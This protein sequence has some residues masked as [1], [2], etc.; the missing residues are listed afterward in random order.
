MCGV[1]ECGACCR[2]RWNRH[3]CEEASPHQ[4]SRPI[5]AWFSALTCC[6][7]LK[8]R[9]MLLAVLCDASCSDRASRSRAL[10]SALP[11]S[12]TVWISCSK[13]SRNSERCE[14]ACTCAGSVDCSD[15]AWRTGQQEAE[16]VSSQP[17]TS[18]KQNGARAERHAPGK[19]VRPRPPLCASAYRRPC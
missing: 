3:S 6:R 5:I 13:H 19:S 8:I 12:E 15:A 17:L 1:V 4:R 11:R 16:R 10:F 7:S 18:H 14:Y 9:S 2:R